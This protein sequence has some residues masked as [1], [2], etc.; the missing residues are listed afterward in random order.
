MP[1]RAAIYLDANASA[2]LC[3]AAGAELLSLLGVQSRAGTPGLQVMQAEVATPRVFISGHLIP[4]PSSPHALGR[5]AKALLRRAHQ[6]VAY[7][8][9]PNVKIDELTLTSSGTE[10]AQS[11]IRAEL[12]PRL[13]RGEKPHWI[14]TAGDHDA[15]VQMISWLTSRGGTVSIL[16]LLPMGVS[17]AG[18]PALAQLEAIFKPETALVSAIWANNETG[19]VTDTE[20]LAKLCSVRGVPLHLDGAQ[21]WGKLPIALDAAC[22]QYVSFSGH[23]IGALS[24]TGVLWSAGRLKRAPLLVGHQEGGFRGG[25]ENLLGAVTL[26]AAA[27]SLGPLAWA[28]KLTPLRDRL[29]QEILRVIPGARIHGAG[30][31]RVANTTNLGFEGV[32]K[33][34]LVAALDLAGY[35]VSPGSACASGI[36]EPSKVLMAMGLSAPASRSAIRVSLSQENRWEELEGFV[37]ALAKAVE[38]A[39]GSGQSGKAAVAAESGA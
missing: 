27:E 33:A 35:C 2:P 20:S 1:A 17:G 24:G 6:Q 14:L 21:A 31:V 16:P 28:A 7:S 38:K 25:T 18:L 10:A 3:E 19:V 11:A 26:G 12:E 8:L 5:R 34:G 37:A 13:L 22:A 9:G 32:E 4:N 39:R 29:E 36:T 23:K 15:H 30:S